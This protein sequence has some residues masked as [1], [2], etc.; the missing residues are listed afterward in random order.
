M[1]D[2][3]GL[4]GISGLAPIVV[5]VPGMGS[6]RVAGAT[7]PVGWSVGTAEKW[8]RSCGSG[9]AQMAVLYSPGIQYLSFPPHRPDGDHYSGL[10]DLRVRARKRKLEG[11][12][13]IE[14]EVG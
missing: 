7:G 13:E 14:R 3:Y 4:N 8:P 11:G 12:R 2:C 1:E 5:I 10:K 9:L 6:W